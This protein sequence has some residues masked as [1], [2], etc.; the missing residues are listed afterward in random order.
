MS[1]PLLDIAAFDIQTGE[2]VE[3]CSAVPQHLWG[4]TQ[5]SL[6]IR[7]NA[8]VYLDTRPHEPDEETGE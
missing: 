2:V 4:N 6:L 8:G 3:L 5:R 1:E 7:Y